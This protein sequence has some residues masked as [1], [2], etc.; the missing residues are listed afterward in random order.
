M[1][2]TV[3]SSTADD[4]VVARPPTGHPAAGPPDPLLT[5]RVAPRRRLG[6]W[7]ATAVV[8]VLVAQTVNGLVTNPFYAWDRFGYWV[9]RP[10]IL[11]GPVVTLEVA[12]L[13]AVLGFAGGV[14]L[15]LA[16]LSRS[17]LL[18]VVSWAYV[19][20]FRSIPI[21]VLLLFLY[22]FT[23]LYARIG[24]GIP[25]GPQF[26][27]TRTTDL[28]SA[29]AVAVLGLSLNEAAYAAEIVRGGILAVDAGQV[30]AAH[31]L[32]LSP[33]R[34]FARIVLPQALR[35]IVPGYVNQLIGL[36]KSCSLVFYVSV[37]DIFGAVQSMSSTY[38]ADIIPL[39]IVATAWYVLLTSA[40]SVVQY[41]V[42]RH[43][44]RGALRTLPPTPLQ[45]LRA[46]VSTPAQ[47]A[48]RRDGVTA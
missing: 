14:L 29:F 32:G 45:R 39:L 8:L 16:R 35:A 27:T 9:F 25:F 40:L 42:E 46:A 3:D 34:L 19:W 6:L 1:S 12:A 18:Q 38:P 13:S 20:L 24:L 26:V 2:S 28:L 43:Y 41:Y 7:V 37:L 48:S 23:A 21:I 17:P 31:A 4:A 47:R 36:V 44:S 30:E 22:N 11:D 33:G 10:V 5:S 15:A